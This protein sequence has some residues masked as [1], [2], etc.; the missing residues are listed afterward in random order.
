MRGDATHP[1]EPEASERE[2]AARARAEMKEMQKTYTAKADAAAAMTKE[3]KEAADEM[4]EQQEEERLLFQGGFLREGGVSEAGTEEHMS[5][6]L[7]ISLEP[8]GCVFASCRP[9]LSLTV[10]LLLL[11]VVLHIPQDAKPCL[12]RCASR[13]RARVDSGVIARAR[14]EAYDA[15]AKAKEEGVKVSEQEEK[16]VVRAVVTEAKR[17]KEVAMVKEKAMMKERSVAEAAQMLKRKAMKAAYEKKMVARQR[18]AAAHQMKTDAR[19]PTNKKGASSLNAAWMS[20]WEQA[21]LPWEANEQEKTGTILDEILDDKT[22]ASLPP[23]SLS[24]A[25]NSTP[26]LLLTLLLLVWTTGR[27]R[28]TSMPRCRPRRATTPPQERHRQAPSRAAA[29]WSGGRIIC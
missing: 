21:K 5:G 17:L 13:K 1:A 24:P 16:E 15:V 25:L 27:V 26:T 4:A 20:P 6:K 29:C 18:A 11:S 7:P 28:P 12:C 3:D 8:L 9:C 2:M 22:C 19:T 23:L 14:E 10:C